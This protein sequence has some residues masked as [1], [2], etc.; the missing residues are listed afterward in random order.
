MPTIRLEN[1]TKKFGKDSI[2]VNQMDLEIKDGE[3]VSLLGPSGCGKTTTLRIIGGFVDPKEVWKRRQRVKSILMVNWFFQ[4]K[5]VSIFHR[6][7]EMS[8]SCFKIMPYGHI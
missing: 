4:K 8:V 2:A 5:K 6:I 1:I 7:K 3:F